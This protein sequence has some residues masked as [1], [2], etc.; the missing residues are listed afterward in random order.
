M[1]P[2]ATDT[3]FVIVSTQNGISLI[4]NPTTLTRLHYFDGKFLRADDLSREQ[5]YLRNLVALSNQSG[6]AGVVQGFSVMLDPN[7]DAILI[8]QGLAIDPTGRVL[9]LPTPQV[10]VGIADLIAASMT[11]PAS[12][13]TSATN[14]ATNGFAPCTVAATAPAGGSSTPSTTDLY[15]ITVGLAE[16]L[17]GTESVYGKLCEEACV[18][19]TDRPYTLEGIIVRAVP[20]SLVVQPPVSAAFPVNGDL[21]YQSR[22]AASYFA[23][24]ASRIGSLL[25][26]SGLADMTWCYGA[27]PVGGSDV[28]IAMLGRSGATT[29]FL[30]PWIVRRERLETPPRR[31]WQLK[32][33]MRPLDIFW[34]QVFQFQC[35]LVHALANAP[36]LSASATAMPS[37]ASTAALAQ[38]T[39]LLQKI[40]LSMQSGAAFEGGTAAIDTVLTQIS[41][42]LQGTF[43][44]PTDRVLLRHGIV[45]LPSAG[46]LP[47]SLSST[48]TVN[49]QVRQLLG[50]GLDYNF[51][52]VRHDYVP[53][54]FEEAQHMDRIS[55]LHGLDVPAEKPEIDVLVPDGQIQ[56]FGVAQAL[57]YQVTNAIVLIKNNTT[58]SATIGSAAAATVG[59]AA[60]LDTTTG[61]GVTATIAPG[62]P[63]L[64]TIEFASM[65]QVF[66]AQGA[67]RAEVLPSGGA[68]FYTAV[69]STQPPP[70]GADTGAAWSPS[71]PRRTRSR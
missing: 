3:G 9:L 20:Y 8:S 71:A 36:E 12:T 16:A 21:W 32:M 37:Q 47:V 51:C 5:D 10:S 31:Y 25:S 42:A 63:A 29:R 7:A 27:C 46:Y 69:I 45:E 58:T 1:A 33:S 14:A 65:R 59:P 56:P 61:G 43:N 68:G 70:V 26:A 55:L 15:V 13:T 50:D 54:A 30:D 6:G 11:P 34:A 28:A 38:A 41:G 40:S 22:V 62:N 57:T 44:G 35:Q 23:D 18:T 48:K 17:C 67:A 39:Q 52:V 19:S 4:P 60:N 53:H 66:V 24:E 64:G 2:A 49:E